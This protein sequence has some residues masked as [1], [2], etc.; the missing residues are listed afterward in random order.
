MVIPR[1]LDR[2][3]RIRHRRRGTRQQQRRACKPADVLADDLE[4]RVEVE[5]IVRHGHAAAYATPDEVNL[6]HGLFRHFVHRH[7]QL[8]RVREHREQVREELPDL[9][10]PRRNRQHACRAFE[11]LQHALVRVVEHD[12]VQVLCPEGVEVVIPRILNCGR[13]VGV[14]LGRL[15]R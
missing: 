12:L 4:L 11:R 13:C 10:L 1:V 9:R 7:R 5:G 15:V 2:C 3:R 6:L 14:V 8:A